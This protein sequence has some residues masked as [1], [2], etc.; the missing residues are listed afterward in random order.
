MGRPK[1]DRI[2]FEKR[3]LQ[4]FPE[5]E[6]NVVEY[7][8][9]GKPLII[10]CLNCEQDIKV[11]KAV[12]FLAK[13]KVNGCVGCK[14]LWLERE[15][16]LLKI[17]RLYNI[18]ETNIKNTHKHYT[19][20]CNSCKHQRTSTMRN[21]SRHLECGCKTNVKRNRTAEEFI[22][23]TNLN[24]ERG[25]YTLIGQYRGQAKPTLLRHSCGFIWTV[26][27]ADVIHGRVFCPKCGAFE[28]KGV[29][30][31]S[32]LL[33]KMSILYERETR[34]ENS[35]QRFDFYIEIKNYKL[36]IEYNGIQHYEEVDFFSTTLEQQKERDVRKKEYCKNNNIHLLSIPYYLS[37]DEI[38]KLII[39]FINK[40]NDYPAKE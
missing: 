23:E 17:K 19:V 6:F 22:N 29:R 30:F 36:A 14:G 34:L 21:L 28:S 27:P 31:I 37:N 10:Q 39:D 15:S 8:S 40:F 16:T 25:S 4:R 24:C 11:S 2:E 9:L 20:Q 7:D 35:R 32:N 5:E 3:V 12:N 1:I 26:R 38:K 13:N 18:V 33:E